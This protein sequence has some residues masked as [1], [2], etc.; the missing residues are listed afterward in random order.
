MQAQQPAEVREPKQLAA[1]WFAVGYY[2]FY[3]AY[4][5]IHQESEF[6]HWL[7]LVLLPLLL[8]LLLLRRLDPAAGLR[9][10]LAEFGLA[11]G[12]LTRGL[13]WAALLGLGLGALQLIVSRHGAEVVAA[14]QSGRWIFLLP[15]SFTLMLLTAG[16]TEEFF[17]R[18]FLLGR[19][20]GVFRNSWA[21]VLLS[22]LA[23]ALYHLPYAYLNPNWP[24]A[25]DFPAALI[26]S[27]IEAF[28]IGIL[29]GCVYLWTRRNLLACAVLH[30]MINTLPAMT[31]IKFGGEPG[32]G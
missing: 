10:T 7:T 6:Q 13:W 28:P 8:L 9:R 18:G 14:F 31:L 26:Q 11:R 17:F 12:N 16:F 25:G 5:F 24:S 19:L 20:L 22:A 21:P 23:F 3:L 2:L 15:L 32:I 27:I 29:L 1:E 30:A 4:L